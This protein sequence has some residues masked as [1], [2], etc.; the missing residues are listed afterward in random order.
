MSSAY[1][2]TAD[3]KEEY[4]VAK[5]ESTAVIIYTKYAVKGVIEYLDI[6]FET[7]EIT[8]TI[9]NLDSEYV[10]EHCDVRDIPDDEIYVVYFKDGEVAGMP[11]HFATELSDCS[12]DFEDE[13]TLITSSIEVNKDKYKSFMDKC[14]NKL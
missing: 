7:A 12:A 14:V 13:F 4:N 2:T 6:S 3:S 9:V 1:I 8:A 5:S 11:N 10:K